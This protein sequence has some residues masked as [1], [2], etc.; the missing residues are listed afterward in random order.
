MAA[1]ERLDSASEA[2]PGLGP[3]G[4]FLTPE[5]RLFFDLNVAWGKIVG[6]TFAC[7]IEGG[8]RAT[9]SVVKRRSARGSSFRPDHNIPLGMTSFLRVHGGGGGRKNI[10]VPGFN[11]RPRTSFGLFFYKILQRVAND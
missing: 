8:G 4:H 11:E 6:D 3:A 1:D 7:S 2:I 9:E 10:P 5:F